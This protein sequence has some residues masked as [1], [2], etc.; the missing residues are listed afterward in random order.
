MIRNREEDLCIDSD[1]FKKEELIPKSSS[2]HSSKISTPTL[3]KPIQH[4]K[5]MNQESFQDSKA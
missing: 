2:Q 3:F 4:Y 5:N 1:S